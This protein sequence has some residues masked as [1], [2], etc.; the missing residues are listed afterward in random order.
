MEN[1]ELKF[2]PCFWRFFGIL[3]PSLLW[4]AIT[5][6]ASID[7]KFGLLILLGLPSIIICLVSSM[8]FIPKGNSVI[9]L[10]NNCIQQKQYRKIVSI[11]LN[12]VD[13][14]KLSKSFIIRAPV[15]L[16]IYSNDKK[17]FFEGTKKNLE[18]FY[19]MCLNDELNKK[20]KKIIFQYDCGTY[21]F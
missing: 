5:L 9:Y 12:E 19:C 11:N 18:K 17:I 7:L 16:I 10:R 2:Y 3:V 8:Y 6:L 1:K 15:L 21:K 13:G 20:I 4:L 14:I